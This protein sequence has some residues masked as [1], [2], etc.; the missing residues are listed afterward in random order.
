MKTLPQQFDENQEVDEMLNELSRLNLELTCLL[1][2]DERLDSFSDEE[3]R[4]GSRSSR[5]MQEAENTNVL[6]LPLDQGFQWWR[7]FETPS[8]RKLRK[9][10]EYLEQVS[11]ELVSRKVNQLSDGNSLIDQYLRNPNLSV[12]DLYGI[13]AD[14]LLA[15]VHTSSFSTA[16]A[17]YHISNDQR[18]Q[19][20]IFAEALKV[21]PN[22]DDPLTPAMMNTE[23]PF[24]RAALKESLR[25]NPISVGVGRILNQDMIIGGY[26]IPKEVSWVVSQRQTDFNHLASFQTVVVTQNQISCRLEKYFPNALK[27]S[28]ER[29]LKTDDKKVDVHPHLLLPFG[30][31][32]RSCIARRFAEQNILIFL[33]RVS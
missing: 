23:I 7:W 17:L 15:G 20:L 9:A 13:A 18:V 24:T 21:M 33:L 27:F 8:Y 10:Q 28:P 2:F 14:L 6:V 22:E 25:L 29:W 16:F 11:V 12:N 30:H 5:L 4:A 32:V 31:G 3:R 26:H 19:D 1:A